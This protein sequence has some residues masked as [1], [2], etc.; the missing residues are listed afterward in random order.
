MDFAYDENGNLVLLSI[1]ILFDGRLGL[2]DFGARYY[3]P[4]LG[5]WMSPDPA[6]Q[7]A[8]PYT[9]GGDPINYIDPTGMFAFGSGFIV[10]W[11]QQ[12]GWGFGVG[13]ADDFSFGDKGKG[14]GSLNLSYI[15]HEDGSDSFSASAGGSYQY[16]I[17]NFYVGAG[18]SYNSV[19]GKS[20]TAHGGAC[21]GN[22][23]VACA[24]HEVGGGAYWDGDGEF[25]GT[26]A[27]AEAY[28]QLVG[29]AVRES[30]GYEQ[31][32]MGMEG[33]GLYA[34]MSIAG[35]HGE[36]S[37]R[38]GFNGSFQQKYNVVTY[39]ADK[40]PSGYDKETLKK[41]YEKQ[42][43]CGEECEV[44]FKKDGSMIVVKRN[45]EGNHFSTD[46]FDVYDD[47][48]HTHAFNSKEGPTNKDAAAASDRALT[49]HYVLLTK[50]AELVQYRGPDDVQN[51]NEQS[52]RLAPAVIMNSWS[53]NA[54]RGWKWDFRY[55]W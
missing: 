15:W 51:E 10:S 39:D 45:G 38:D 43:N 11:D 40:H 54:N 31:G 37:Q 5:L 55:R 6:G 32:F 46:F 36:W 7:F 13:L 29:G 52:A 47:D 28:G 18:F 19:S 22:P 9:Y 26:T 44:M 8:N 17:F 35:L 21:V 49:K 34:G 12:H 16:W 1:D 25:M 27:Y 42:I 30:H 53:I 48:A 33:R 3:D 20:L 24:G 23:S 41:A 4:F 14:G 50:T 2:Y